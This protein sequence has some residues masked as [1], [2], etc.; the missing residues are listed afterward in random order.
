MTDW[1]S[2]VVLITSADGKRH[3]S[4]FVARRAGAMAHV[5]TCA[6]VVNDLGPDGLEANGR[7]AKV[8]WDGTKDG[9]DLAV[10]AAEGLTEEALT[11]TRQAAVGDRV[12]AVGF[13]QVD[14]GR[15]AS[16]RT[17]TLR[18]ATQLTYDPARVVKKHA[19]WV[20]TVDDDGITDGYSGGPVV[21]ADTGLV[22]GVLGLR[23]K[24]TADAISITNL[25]AW[26]DAPPAVSPLRDEFESLKRTS[27]RARVLSF[28][29]GAALAAA[30]V[31]VAMRRG[32]LP[33]VEPSVVVN[34]PL[35]GSTTSQ[36]DVAVSATLGWQRSRIL[37]KAGDK[38]CLEPRG[39]ATVSM[40]DV[41]ARASV[42]TALLVRHAPANSRLGQ[43]KRLIPAP[44]LDASNGFRFGWTGPEGQLGVKDGVFDPCLLSPTDGWGALLAVELGELGYPDL[45]RRD[46]LQVLHEDRRERD[47]VRVIGARREYTFETD[48]Y[49]AFIVNDAVLSPRSTGVCA[50]PTTVLPIAQR[51]LAADLGHRI[52][53]E[54]A[55]LLRYADNGGGFQV[56]IR[57]G[58][59]SLNNARLTP[60]AT[61]PQP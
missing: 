1:T 54:T 38:V 58:A 47:A 46:P 12:L 22:I 52:G 50:E 32:Q 60:S 27:L 15:R 48:G 8:L 41:E 45:D 37:Y 34:S 36:D 10:I 61:P 44:V 55:P 3:G 9:I 4:G 21:A 7:P 57:R 11:L 17:G 43:M 5:V 25:S 16:A 49:L 56:R 20:L 31:V 35:I 23:G 13:T 30:I 14:R 24:G 39:Q 53:D 6:H 51:A 2:H 29:A 19:G 40:P 26:K 18:E 42:M 28:V 33:K 59:C